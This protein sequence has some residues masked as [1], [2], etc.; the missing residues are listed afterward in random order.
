MRIALHIDRWV[1][2][3][4]LVEISGPQHNLRNLRTHKPIFRNHFICKMRPRFGA[5]FRPSEAKISPA[6]AGIIAAKGLV[7]LCVAGSAR[8]S[9]RV[10]AQGATAGSE[11]LGVRI[12]PAEPPS[13][14]ARW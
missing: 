7:I 1:D 12:R 2:G 14:G 13:V 9:G 6:P 4:S 8:R 5:R 3:D 10:C 11:G